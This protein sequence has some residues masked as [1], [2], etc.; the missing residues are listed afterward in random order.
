MW[1][2]RWH[3]REWCVSSVIKPLVVWSALSTSAIVSVLYCVSVSHISL[4]GLEWTC[5]TTKTVLNFRWD[6]CGCTTLAASR[7]NYPISDIWKCIG[8]G[9]KWPIDCAC[10]TLTIDY[11]SVNMSN[12]PLLTQLW[13]KSLQA[14]FNEVSTPFVFCKDFV[15]NECVCALNY[16]I[17]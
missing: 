7:S 9:A 6:M 16:C 11:I 8:C 14:H 3:I 2:H 1:K 13:M 15:L 10:V 4:P 5:E 12:N 17:L